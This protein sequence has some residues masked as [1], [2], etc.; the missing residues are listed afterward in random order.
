MGRYIAQ[1]PRSRGVSSPEISSDRDSIEC[2]G[3][4]KVRSAHGANSNVES[5]VTVQDDRLRK[6]LSSR[7]KSESEF[8]DRKYAR[9]QGAPRH[10]AAQPPYHIYIRML[11]I[12]GNLT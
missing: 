4:A 11:K 3:T 1:D 10:Y 9:G 12:K 5:T 8:H 7:H 6:A 2:R